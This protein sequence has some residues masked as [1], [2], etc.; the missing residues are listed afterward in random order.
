MRAIEGRRQ[1]AVP[2]HYVALTNAPLNAQQRQDIR[3]IASAALVGAEVHLLDAAD[4]A[5]MLDNHPNL[6][7]AFPQLLS[8]RDLD[9]LLRDAVNAEQLQ[10]SSAIVVESQDLRDVF[11]ATRAYR[12]AWLVLQE[13]G[14]LVLEGPPQVG[15]TAIAQMIALTQMLSGWDYLVCAKPGEPGPARML[16]RSRRK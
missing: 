4:I 15:N 16:E 10:R 5:A 6:R 13:H 12:H 3:G 9:S 11:V 14:F 7:R 2:A 8:F 1:R